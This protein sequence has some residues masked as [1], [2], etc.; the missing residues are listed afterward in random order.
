MGTFER[1][2]LSPGPCPP[3]SIETVSGLGEGSD[4]TQTA[5]GSE[6]SWGLGWCLIGHGP[7]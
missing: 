4:L 1:G 6:R 2:V 7:W 3:L 5:G